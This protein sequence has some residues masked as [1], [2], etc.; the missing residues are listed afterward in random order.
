MS[1]RLPRGV[2][3]VILPGEPPLYRYRDLT[4]Y[5]A[6]PSPVMFAGR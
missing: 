5:V 6:T 4:G 1:R 2:C 3:V